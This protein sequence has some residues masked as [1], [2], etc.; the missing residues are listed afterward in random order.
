MLVDFLL[1]CLKLL[2][3]LNLLNFLLT[4]SFYLPLFII[5]DPFFYKLNLQFEDL[6]C[7]KPV[8][9]LDYFSNIF[10]LLIHLKPN[11]RLT[12]NYYFLVN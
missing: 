9:L 2:N 11:D 7:T 10:S 5:Q 12:T 4:F 8:T 3:L 6:Y 1:N